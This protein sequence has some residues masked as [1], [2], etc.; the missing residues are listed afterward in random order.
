MIAAKALKD[1]I[2]RHQLLDYGKR[3]NFRAILKIIPTFREQIVDQAKLRVP[4]RANGNPQDLTTY[5]NKNTNSRV[6]L[7]KAKTSKENK[8]KATSVEEE[9]EWGWVV[10]HLMCSKLI[11]IL[12]LPR[13]TQI[14]SPAWL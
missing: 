1:I 12:R 13:E 3:R 10:S 2:F 9:S 8:T 14:P 11:V 5:L 4:N 6:L 7:G